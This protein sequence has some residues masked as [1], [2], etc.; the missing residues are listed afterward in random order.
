MIKPQSLEGRR[1]AIPVLLVAGIMFGLGGGLKFVVGEESPISDFP[2][3]M[4]IVMFC[5]CGVL[6]VLGVLNM[7]HVGGELSKLRTRAKTP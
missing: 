7:I 6:L 2:T 3:W 4:P 5:M 1:T